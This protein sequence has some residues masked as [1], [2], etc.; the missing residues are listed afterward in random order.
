MNFTAF[1]RFCKRLGLLLEIRE[2]SKCYPMSQEARSVQSVLMRAAQHWGVRFENAAYVTG[3]ST[4]GNVF[5][6]S[7]PV[8]RHAAMND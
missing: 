8:R 5:L 2:D 6:P 4:E 3:V 7:R 1:E